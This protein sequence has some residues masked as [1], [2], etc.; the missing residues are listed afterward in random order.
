MDE[1]KV[2]SKDM[3]T[4]FRGFYPVIID[5]ETAGFDYKKNAVL[6]IAAVT[7]T[8]DAQNQLIPDKTYAYHVIPFASATFDADALKF[9]G[10]DPYHPF[11]FAKSESDVLQD[12]FKQVKEQQ[13]IHRC[14]RAVMVAHNPIFDMGFFQAMITRCEIKKNPFHAFTTFDTAT[15]AAAAYGQTVLAKAMEKAEIEF[16]AKEAHSAIYDAE[17]TA[18]LFCKI[19]NRCWSGAQ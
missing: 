8:Y 3:S 16:N 9:N 6:E 19:I 18:E 4:R 2:S 15:L 12:L 10:I 14:S 17:K 11:R 13:K 5:I 7:V 1:K